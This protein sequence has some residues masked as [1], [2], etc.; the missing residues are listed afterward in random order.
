MK[1]KVLVFLILS[2]SVLL[3][4]CA[5]Y[6][7][8]I[9]D[10]VYVIGTGELPVG[11]SLTDET[12]YAHYRENRRNDEAPS[13][14]N[15]RGV[16]YQPMYPGYYPHYA[17]TSYPYWN[18]WGYYSGY[19]SWHYPYGCDFYYTYGWNPYYGMYMPYSVF[20]YPYGLNFGN[21][22][23]PY[24]FG[25]N[26]NYT[27]SPT[28]PITV[29]TNQHV[30]PRGSWVSN[31]NPANRPNSQLGVLKSLQST[32]PSSVYSVSRSEAKQIESRPFNLNEQ[33]KEKSPLIHQERIKDNPTIPSRGNGPT[34]YNS[35][36][37]THRATPTMH[38]RPVR[39]NNP[40]STPRQTPASRPTPSSGR[41]L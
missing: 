9:D 31:V 40:P 16:F 37:P 19:P 6:P 1:S 7:D 32:V 25:P 15:D 39:Y 36:R 22:Y 38:E 24:Y 33:R 34:H 18:S 8:L 5:S 17:M 20:G 26:Q 28:Q 29:S 14:F 27:G 12:S 30:G 10:D 13:Y 21:Y 35:N 11:E 23:S 4:G 3:N 2:F 41:R